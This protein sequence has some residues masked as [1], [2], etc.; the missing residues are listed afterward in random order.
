M[1]LEDPSRYISCAQ[2][3][4]EYVAKHFTVSGC[5]HLYMYMYPIVCV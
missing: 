1:K 3:W 2:V 5:G 4:I